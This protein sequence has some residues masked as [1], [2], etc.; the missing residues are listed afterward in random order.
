MDKNHLKRE[1]LRKD[2]DTNFKSAARI[3]KNI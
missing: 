1:K 3:K 2:L